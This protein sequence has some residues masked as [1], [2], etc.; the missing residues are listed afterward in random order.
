MYHDRPTF[1]LVKWSDEDVDEYRGGLETKEGVHAVS[2]WSLLRPL[3]PSHTQP[4]GSI[5]ST[6]STYTSL[7]PRPIILLNRN[8]LSLIL[9]TPSLRS[10]PY[11]R[12]F[13]DSLGQ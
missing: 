12:S 3:T 8:Y 13:T 6:K 11:Q 1:S 9:P 4:D 5:K 7:L 10:S 2:P